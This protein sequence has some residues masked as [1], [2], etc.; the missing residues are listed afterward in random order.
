MSIFLTILLAVQM[1]S[2]VAMIGLILV[3]H[4]KEIGRA[5]V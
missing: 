2:A 1:I 5:H 4:G 3:Q